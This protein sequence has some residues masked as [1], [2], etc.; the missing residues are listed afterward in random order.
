MTTSQQESNQTGES[1]EARFKKVANMIHS[2]NNLNEILIGLND[3]I[4]SLFDAERA[5]IYLVDRK[6]RE[7]FS[8]VKSGDFPS[9]IRIPI[10]PSS[11]SGFVAT[12]GKSVHVKDVHDR[13]E[14]SLIDPKLKFDD[15]W[16][17]KTGFHT[18]KVLTVPVIF[19]KSLVGVVQLINRKDRKEFAEEDKQRLGDIAETLGIAFHNQ[20]KLTRRIDPK[21][22]F[23]KKRGLLE[24]KALAEAQKKARRS[25]QNIEEV[26]VNE[27]K[28]PAKELSESLALFYG[29]PNEIL[30]NTPYNPKPLL[31]G[32]N[33]EYFR[34]SLWVPLEIK[35]GKIILVIN[36][37]NDHNKLHEIRQLYRTNKI[38]LRFALKKE[39]LDFLATFGKAPKVEEVTGADKS[40]GDLLEEMKDLDGGILVAGEDDEEH[41]SVDDSAIVL[42]ARKIIEDAFVQGASDIHIEPYGL[43]TDAVVRFRIDGRCGKV[44]E[45]PRSHIKALT[46]RFKILA[47]LD[48][49]ERR[50]PQDGKIK[51]KTSRGKEIELRVATVP[52]AG[53]NEDIVL[54]VLASNE[55]LPLEKIMPQQTFERFKTVIEKPY[56]IVLVVGPTGSGKTTTLHSGLGYINTP[57][58][59][60]WT[61]EDPVEITQY[62]LRQVQ[63]I[64]KIG[65]TFASA[66]RAFLRADPDVIMVGEMRDKETVTMGLEASLTG[67]L[68]FSTL[69]TN[70]APE[71]ITRLVDMGM[72]PFN[73]ADALLGILAQRLTRTLCSCKEEYAPERQEYDHLRELYGELFDERVKIPYTDDLRLFRPSSGCEKCK[74]TG[75]KGRIGLYELLVSS[76]NIKKQIINRAT[77]EELRDAA[78][79]EGM[80]TLLQDGIQDIFSGKTDLNQVMSVCS[81]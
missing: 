55:P 31:K 17:K 45:V 8:R 56:G 61:A 43:K 76:D 64:P 77:V 12:T 30:M 59:K 13:E 33:L 41:T 34:K 46:S 49:S 19:Q 48:I 69:H 25:R 67:H 16:D 68:V 23:L 29:I 18:Q 22:D 2:A 28:V 47:Q 57:D 21:L 50:K 6:N 53:G 73:F 66:M 7:I 9:E 40:F 42:L 54:R 58:R 32:K 5:T 38:E 11:I 26:L 80:V 20:F 36:D 65:Y 60:I 10:E 14:L 70:S 44:L 37:P 27:Y 63:V 24:D 79:A 74:D 71:T 39:I 62:G 15:S 51:F 35:D 4:V 72:D 3:E 75:Y 81:H 1:F 52:T 78:I